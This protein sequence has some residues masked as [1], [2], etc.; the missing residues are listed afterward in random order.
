LP[1]LENLHRHFK[2]RPF[3]VVAIDLQE[4]N[5]TVKNFILDNGLTYMNL[6]DEKGNVAK[7]YG[8]TS[9]PV[10]FLIDTKGNMVGSAMGFKKWDTDEVKSL[11]EKLMEPKK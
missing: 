10:K 3:A 4:K 7:M 9:T 2:D 8:V 6:I 5:S 1:S 11:I